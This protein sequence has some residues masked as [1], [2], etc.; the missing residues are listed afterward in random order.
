MSVLRAYAEMLPRLQA[1]EQL[2]TLNLL[3]AGGSMIVDKHGYQRLVGSL[4]RAAG[5]EEPRPKTGDPWG[6]GIT[7]VT[8]RVAA[9]G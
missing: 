3:T 2:V 6:L 1:E 8:E 4:K 5:R 9:S 7:V